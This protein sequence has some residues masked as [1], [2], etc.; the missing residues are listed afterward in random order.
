ML[1]DGANAR[2]AFGVERPDRQR[3]AVRADQPDGHHR[4]L[5]GADAAGI[6]RAANGLEGD[7]EQAV[8]ALLLGNS[9][10]HVA[11][12]GRGPEPDIAGGIG[13]GEAGWR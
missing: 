4:H 10:G 6:A 8:Q 3:H 2:D 12:A 13:I 1:H 11:G 5:E 7:L 9:A